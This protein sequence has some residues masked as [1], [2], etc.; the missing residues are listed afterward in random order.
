MFAHVN[1]IGT[2]HWEAYAPAIIKP[3]FAIHGLPVP[4]VHILTL[5]TLK[6]IMDFKSPIHILGEDMQVMTKRAINMLDSL[7]L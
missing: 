4:I 5:H 6:Q 2:V 1:P 3:V 7:H